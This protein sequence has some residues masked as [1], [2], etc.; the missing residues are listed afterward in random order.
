M[1]RGKRTVFMASCGECNRRVGT[2]RLLKQNSKG[3]SWKDFKPA[4]FCSDCRKIQPL[5]LKEERH[6]D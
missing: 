1:P 2:V 4:K 3:V 6:S 5:K